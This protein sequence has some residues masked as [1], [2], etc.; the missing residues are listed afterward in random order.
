MVGFYLVAHRLELSINDALSGTV[1]DD[2]DE[3]LLRIYYLYQ[4]A[5]RKHRELRKIHVMYAGVMNYE[6]GVKPKKASGTRWIT[7]KL[8]AMKICLDKWG[9]YI[10][11]LEDHSKD[12][13]VK[14]EDSAKMT[15]YLRKWK[16]ARIPL[17]LALFIDMRNTVNF[18]KMLQRREC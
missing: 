11:H 16:K 3:M 8:E 4:K 14:S 9:L 2:I 7:N 10:Q 6:G 13:K 15:G 18:I 5:P 12:K 17:L 1:F